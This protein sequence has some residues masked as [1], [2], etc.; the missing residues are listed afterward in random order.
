MFQCKT[1][2]HFNY[3][4]IVI[5][6]TTTATSCNVHLADMSCSLVKSS[7]TIDCILDMCHT[8]WPLF[9]R[10]TS[11]NSSIDLFY[12]IVTQ[13]PEVYLWSNNHINT[14]VQKIIVVWHN[15]FCISQAVKHCGYDNVSLD[16]Q[17]LPISSTWW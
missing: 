12:L 9:P 5:G 17:G 1:Q 4:D 11:Y 8:T 10:Y 6:L 13:N 7:L 14:A 16:Q 15:N 3:V 2:H